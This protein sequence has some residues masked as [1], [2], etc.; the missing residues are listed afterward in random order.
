[1]LRRVPAAFGLGLLLVCVAVEARLDAELEA[2]V[3]RLE[4]MLESGGLLDLVT[5]LDRLQEQVQRLQG[6]L[7][8]QGH[9]L[10]QLRERQQHLSAEPAPGTAEPRGG[11]PAPEGEPPAP[12]PSPAASLVPPPQ[13][14][15]PPPPPAEPPS[16]ASSEQDIYERALGLL[17]NR[18]YGEAAQAFQAY[19]GA[20]PR[21]EYAPNAAYWLGEAYSV[22]GKADQAMAA[23]RKV[24]DDYPQSAKVPD[25]MLKIG[26]IQADQG[27]RAEALQ[28]LEQVLARY[29]DSTAARLAQDRLERLKGTAG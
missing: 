28:T 27:H 8:V 2:R 22:N 19:L 12:P 7:D 3:A 10:E 11:E 14:G 23:F 26:V 24:L 17:R 9:T 1:M 4:R 20:Y 25:A 21:G 16:A 13:F 5:R 29:P 15:T 6:Q 18:R